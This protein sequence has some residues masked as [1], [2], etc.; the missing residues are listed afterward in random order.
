MRRF[1]VPLVIVA[2]TTVLVGLV[3]LWRSISAESAP[4][5]VDP[6]VPTA[7]TPQPA[8]TSPSAPSVPAIRAPAAA[9]PRPR[10]ESAEPR[11]GDAPP[12]LESDSA[13]PGTKLNTKNLQWGITQMRA[14]V[15]ANEPKVVECLQ[16]AA[17]SG[18][19]PTGDAT[20]TFIAAKRGDKIVIEDTNI[21]GDG[22][23]LQGDA[24]LDCLHTTSKAMTFEGLP[25]EAEAV[26]ITRSVKVENGGLVENKLVKFSYIR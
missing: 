8:T 11:S 6:R 17:T 22:T 9:P 14:Q 19:R 7:P 1:A 26:F 3:F 5:K 2:S 10:V 23:T 4:V 20:L 13:P 16:Q 25:R 18:Q 24:L 12:T 21:D 15:A